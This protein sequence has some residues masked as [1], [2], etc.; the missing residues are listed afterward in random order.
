MLSAFVYVG[1]SLIKQ[2]QAIP[3]QTLAK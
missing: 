3:E 1:Q 2:H